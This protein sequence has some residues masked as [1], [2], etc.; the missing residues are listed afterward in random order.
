MYSISIK[1]TLCFFHFRVFLQKWN[2]S[3]KTR[4]KDSVWLKLTNLFLYIRNQTMNKEYFSQEFENCVNAMDEDELR[5]A[6]FEK[7]RTDR[8]WQK[9]IVR[10]YTQNWLSESVDAEYF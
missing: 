4:G 1:N 6:I 2:G 3:R 7:A 5:A 10:Q 8:Q 9:E